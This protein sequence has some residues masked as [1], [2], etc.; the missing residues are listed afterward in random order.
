[1]KFSLPSIAIA[2]VLVATCRG[3]PVEKRA[4]GFTIN[5][6]E[7]K[8]ID[9]DFTKG[10]PYSPLSASDTLTVKYTADGDAAVLKYLSNAIIKYGNDDIATLSI[11]EGAPASSGNGQLTFKFA[12]LPLQ[13]AAD[14]HAQIQ[15]LLKTLTTQNQATIN[16]HGTSD[17]VAKTSAGEQ[18]FKGVPFGNDVTLKGMG[19]LA[20]AP[21]KFEQFK[22]VGGTKDGIQVDVT[23]TLQNPSDIA[24]HAEDRQPCT[25]GS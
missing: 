6:V 3:A 24:I 4:E 18:A 13:G 9:L 1:M 14:K 23:S 2:L 15:E 20:S 25:Q 16:L 8:S 19:G 11:P 17:V 7:L 10:D 22:V 21:L 12:D 5:G